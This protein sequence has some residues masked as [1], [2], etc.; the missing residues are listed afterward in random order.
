MLNCE[1]LLCLLSYAS[2]VVA[3]TELNGFLL[4]FSTLVV[5]FS[6]KQIIKEYVQGK[7]HYFFLFAPVSVAAVSYLSTCF[8][9]K[10]V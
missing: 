10:R 7:T 6:V 4:L 1:V 3:P 2:K 8:I 5:A 9:H